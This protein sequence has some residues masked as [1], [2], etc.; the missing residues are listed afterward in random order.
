MLICELYGR[1]E[2]IS[3]AS[4]TS[5]RTSPISARLGESLSSRWT[6]GQ[7][8]DQEEFDKDRTF[9]LESQG[10]HVLRFW[11]SD[12]M[13]KVEEVMGLILSEFEKGKAAPEQAVGQVDGSQQG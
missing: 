6:G 10:Y 13:N 7:H 9:F 12:V 3:G 4:T 1:K 8:L 11:N 2:S 5:G